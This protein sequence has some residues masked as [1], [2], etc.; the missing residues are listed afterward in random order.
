M[1]SIY[2]VSRLMLP[3]ALL[4]FLFS[5]TAVAQNTSTGE[6]NGID[7][8]HGTWAEAKAK[9][10]E[11]NKLIFVDAYAV[12]CGP[13]KWMARNTFTDPAVGEVFNKKFI[14]V[15]MDMER[16]EGPKL[17]RKWGI[18]A[19]P[20]LLFFDADGKEVKRAL[21]AKRSTDFIQLGE[22]ATL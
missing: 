2:R 14:N 21:G 20:T 6:G 3:A 10:K 12:W 7:F 16:G 9:A 8:F 15:K 5:S 19:Y 22:S 18:R 13:C 17:A 1:Q 4:L 11:E